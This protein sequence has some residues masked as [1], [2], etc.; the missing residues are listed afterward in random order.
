MAFF[1]ATGIAGGVT[2]AVGFALASAAVGG[3][4]VVRFVFLSGNAVVVAIPVAVLFSR[5]VGR[6]VVAADVVGGGYGDAFGDGRERARRHRR[7]GDGHGERSPVGIGI[8]SRF[9]AGLGG[10]V[11]QPK[12]E[13]EGSG[14]NQD[15]E[16]DV[17]AM[18]GG[19]VLFHIGRLSVWNGEGANAE[20]GGQRRRQRSAASM[21]MKMKSSRVKP[22]S[23]E[24]P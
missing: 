13:G 11:F 10:T 12:D 19:V 21:R 22:H 16:P 9:A 1:V 3:C 6:A 20:W 23:D 15:E 7:V 4:D 24:P 18:Q 14:D 5:F 8:V 17:A 2:G